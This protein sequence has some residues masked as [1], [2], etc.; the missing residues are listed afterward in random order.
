MSHSGESKA[1]SN[2]I[3]GECTPTEFIRPG[4]SGELS[5]Q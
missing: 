4:L 2:S 1:Q 3:F 5:C